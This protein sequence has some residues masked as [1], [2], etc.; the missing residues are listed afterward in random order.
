VLNAKNKIRGTGGLGVP[1]LRYTFVII[2]WKLEEWDQKTRKIL[3]I[4]TIHH[5]KGD[6]VRLYKREMRGKRLVTD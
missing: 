3:I 2:N 1:I 5:Q 4:Y 6:I